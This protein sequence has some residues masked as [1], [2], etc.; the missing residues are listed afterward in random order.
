MF[1]VRWSL[2]AAC[3]I[4]GPLAIAAV[5][6]SAV[7]PSASA[8]GDS[9]AMPARSDVS[10]ATTPP[11]QQPL[12]LTGRDLVTSTEAA[13]LAK[14]AALR[15]VG[16][17]IVVLNYQPAAP[18]HVRDRA[19]GRLL[20]EI[21]TFG[22]GPDEFVGVY[23][24]DVAEDADDHVWVYDLTRH[25]M[26]LVD[27]SDAGLRRPNPIV[28]W[29]VL[30]SDAVL[31][32]P[33]W[34]ADTVFS[35]GFFHTG[36]L[37]AFDGTG[38]FA[39]FLAT[40]PSKAGEPVHVTQHAYHSAMATDTKR[41]VFALVTQYAGIVELY[42]R[43]GERINVPRVPDAFAPR[44]SMVSRQGEPTF[45]RDTDS[46]HGYLDV[47]GAGDVF[48]ALFSG[49][50][51]DELGAT[52]RGRDVHAFG[53]DGRLLATYRLP[54]DATAISTDPSG[55]TLYVVHAPQNRTIT[56]YSLPARLTAS[57]AR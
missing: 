35:P 57:A 32:A 19:T 22:R 40:A 15:V 53:L 48:L 42:R 13:P 4:A 11:L 10:A 37:A 30:R 7:T 46:R 51:R 25:R 28:R 41:S 56:A 17:R 5:A 36:R 9:L 43:T 33:I 39:K 12:L 29:V 2:I 49:K 44:Y 34:S 52:P 6:H 8:T 14:A 47:A 26:A 1:Y 21:G 54:R 3:A 24:V 45:L 31:T 16:N 50:H 20:K 18:I 27:V 38:K 23:T 55:R